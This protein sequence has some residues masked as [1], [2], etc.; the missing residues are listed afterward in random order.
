MPQGSLHRSGQGV[1]VLVVPSIDSLPLRV[2]CMALREKLQLTGF[3]L[4]QQSIHR[5]T[6][7]SDT[8]TPSPIVVIHNSVENLSKGM[9]G[10]PLWTAWK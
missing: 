1:T 10:E 2:P 3:Q 6:T 8:G 5:Y 9:L 7:N 4:F